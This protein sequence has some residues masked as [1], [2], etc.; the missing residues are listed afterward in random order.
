M[1]NI[2]TPSRILKFGEFQRKGHNEKEMDSRHIKRIE[3]GKNLYLTFD[4]CPSSK[5]DVDVIKF[6]LDSD[7]EASF[8]PC[9]QWI[10]MNEGKSD[11][12]F[13]NNSSFTIGGHGYKHIDPLKQSDD[14]QIEDLNKA[15]NYWKD[16]GK[17]IK[18]YRVPYGHPTETTFSFLKS[19]GIKC[20]SWS[21]PV[22][23]KK[24]ERAVNLNPNEAAKFY[25][26]NSL[27]DGDI[28]LMHAN[29]E[30]INTLKVLKDLTW[31]L[32]KLG[33]KFK[34]LPNV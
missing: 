22:F 19:K 30:G 5:L 11:L 32:S 4:I 34:K 14:E 24:E 20:A 3:G 18:W 16:A 7:Y 28:I 6:L 1:K 10:E 26:E 13:L 29:G 2:N 23:D 25:I 15:L 31:D 27:I 8:F 17:S 12:T 21:G 9:V 33:Y